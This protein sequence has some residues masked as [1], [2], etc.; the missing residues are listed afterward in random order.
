MQGECLHRGACRILFCSNAIWTT[1]KKAFLTKV[2]SRTAS[3][4]GESHRDKMVFQIPNLSART[5]KIQLIQIQLV[6]P[7]LWSEPYLLLTTAAIQKTSRKCKWN[8]FLPVWG[9]CSSRVH[10]WGEGKNRGRGR[11][12]WLKEWC[13]IWERVTQFPALLQVLFVP[14][15]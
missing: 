5:Q 1:V 3:R 6:W 9:F 8:C 4:N 11:M 7:N 13:E 15:G 12:A 14:L 2:T 10:G